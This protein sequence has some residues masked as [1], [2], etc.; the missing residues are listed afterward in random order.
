M[1]WRISL[2]GAFDRFNYGDVLF[3]R[4]A[5]H[6][7]RQSLPDAEID[8]Y[9]L[10]AADLRDEGG[11]V[12]K[13][14]S[15]LYA[16]RI[17]PD[18]RH[19]VIMTGGELLAPSWGQMVEHLVPPGLSKML[20]WV[21]HRTSYPLWT[22][23]WRRVFSCKNL[24]PWTLDPRDLPSGREPAQVVYNAVGGVRTGRLGKRVIAWQAEA[25]KRATWLTVRDNPTAQAVAGRG[26]PAPQVVP[27][28]AVTMA[29][30]V[31]DDVL[32]RE[33]ATILAAAGLEDRPYLC[34]QLAER[35][36]RDRDDVVA[37]QL[38]EVHR[39]TGLQ[40]LSFAIGRAS[41]H[42]DQITSSR[43]QTRLRDAPWFGVA[44]ETMTVDQ[45]M[46][47]IAGS[48]AYVGTSLH[49]YITA[50]V[51]QRARVG[52]EPS[53]KKVAGFRDAW[54]NP[55]MPA[56]QQVERIADSVDQALAVAPNTTPDATVET[57]KRSF[58]AML[59]RAGVVS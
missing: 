51:F 55:E 27:D 13:P 41:A 3:A 4:V 59:A 50:F 6:M 30:L 32:K 46:A 25:L 57:Y 18:T 9:A 47:L 38:R 44:P 15:A 40:V 53:V 14:L 21:H 17:P 2:V 24:Q 29:D 42:D 12:C 56:G 54:D 16:Q 26:L 11:V 5:E 49:G 43:L 34:V 10:R 28:S 23:L 36:S 52:L 1:V 22:P 33:R 8:F 37:E 48:Q 19:L 20:L 31:P 7:V 45:V 35:W 58:A 39:R